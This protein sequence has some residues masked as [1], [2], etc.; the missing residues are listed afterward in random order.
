MSNEYIEIIEKAKLD[1]VDLKNSGINKLK[2]KKLSLN[3]TDLNKSILKRI[4]LRKISLKKLFLF[5]IAIILLVLNLN[6]FLNLRSQFNTISV[7]IH[8]KGITRNQ[9]INIIENE[10]KKEDSKFTEINSFGILERQTVY[11][12]EFNRKKSVT[13]YYVF[14][15]MEQVLPMKLIHG[16]LPSMEDTYGCVI[17]IKTALSLFGNVN[18]LGLPIKWE[19]RTYYIRGIVSNT[20]PVFMFQSKEEDDIFWNFEL[21]YKEQETARELTSQ[22]MNMFS[23]D[24]TII[25][26]GYIVR[27]L[28]NIVGLPYL[29]IIVYGIYY[30]LSFLKKHKNNLSLKETSRA[31]VLKYFGICISCSIAVFYFFLYYVRTFI[32]IPRRFIPTRWSDFSHWAT[33]I[34]NF[35]QHYN[36]IVSI[37]PIKKDTVLLEGVTFNIGI[38][39]V[40]V[41]SLLLIY[42]AYRNKYEA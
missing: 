28:G 35:K 20:F 23:T 19:E 11:E 15:F 27:L 16:T 39:I 8:D 26:G 42:F 38:S 17:D 6:T 25:E 13:L 21:K 10:Q 22:F 34:N 29:S 18:V 9:L 24:Y 32:Y 33:I 40:S 2:L 1:K 36:E 14:G 7:R 37:M 5:I 30:V 31:N 4:S 3:E 41:M 12:S